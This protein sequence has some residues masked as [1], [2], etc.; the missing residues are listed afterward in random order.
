M[1]WD[2][3][4]IFVASLNQYITGRTSQVLK[5]A[6]QSYNPVVFSYDQEDE[7]GY[8]F[9]LS[10]QFD[11]KPTLDEV[12]KLFTD[13]ASRR[14]LTLRLNSIAIQEPIALDDIP[15]TARETGIISLTLDQISNKDKAILDKVIE[16]L[17]SQNKL[18][19]SVWDEDGSIQME[20]LIF[21]FENHSGKIFLCIRSL[22]TSGRAIIPAQPL[23]EDGLW[24]SLRHIFYPEP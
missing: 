3:S 22:N 11:Y 1:T 18:R 6:A 7:D 12:T 4:A 10:L 15:N 8:P 20:N 14:K 16:E 24:T 9:K 2:I 19:S 21:S 13:I 5:Q 17:C 23:D